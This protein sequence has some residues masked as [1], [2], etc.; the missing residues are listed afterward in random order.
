[1]PDYSTLTSQINQ[2]KTAAST[3]MTSGTLDANELALVGASLDSMANSLGVADI[4]QAVVDSIVSINAAKD[5]AISAFNS[6]TNGTRL[7]AAEADID[8]LQAR[9]TNIEGFVATNGAQY[10]T[11]QSTVSALQTSVS[12]VPSSW[13]IVTASETI[14]NRDRV[15]VNTGGITVTL[16]LNPS[17]GFAVHIVDSTG[18]AANVNFTI[19]RNSQKIMG[20]SEDLIVNTNGAAIE[21]VYVD[22]VRGWAIV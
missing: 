14:L 18:N 19:G 17:L 22:A 2:F 4:N 15:F 5:S 9:A 11:L 10:T 16:P 13:R 7:T 6:G 1:M 21:L 12:T 8:D 3:L 20:L